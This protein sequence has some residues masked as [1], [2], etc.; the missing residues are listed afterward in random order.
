MMYFGREQ[1]MPIWRSVADLLRHTGGV[2]LFDY[3]PLSD[4]PP[5]SALGQGLH[6]LRERVF[7]IRSD[8]AYDQRSRSDVA[9]DLR[10]A[11]FDEVEAID[12]HE[13][14]QPWA[15]PQSAEPSRTI[16]YCCRNR[17]PGHAPE[18]AHV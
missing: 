13:V 11:G 1:Q 4:E 8:F 18:T 3:I 14:A 10:S 17:A 6:L 7:G 9:A 12:T 16:V 2:Y 5:R 15:L